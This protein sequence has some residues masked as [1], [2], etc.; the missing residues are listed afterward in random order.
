MEFKEM[1]P[2]TFWER[3][4]GTLGMVVLAALLIGG[5]VL[6]YSFL[7]TLILLAE[8]TLYLSG[9]LIAL[10]AVI[11]MVLDPKMRNLVGFAYKSVM[12][13]ITSIFVNIDPI[14]VLKSYI[15]HLDSSLKKMDKQVNQLRGQMHKL[16]ELIVNN[17]KEIQTNL[18]DAA[19]ARD[20]AKETQMVLKTRKAGRLQESN[21]RL[22]ELYK[23]ME[24][25]YRILNKM[26]DASYI[27]SEDLKDQILVKET[28]RNAILA[29]HSAMNS[30]LSILK[31]DPDK[32]AMF[33]MALENIS[34]DVS[35]KIGEMESFMNM[36]DK[37]MK[38]IDLQNGV[39][40][41][42]GLKMLE[43]WEK[44]SQSL[45]LG[46]AKEELVLKN[47]SEVETLDINQPIKQPQREAGHVNQYDTFFE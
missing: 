31:G 8:N 33:D 39:F 30:A 24:S 44:K 46:E 2:K 36:S 45:L 43:E 25:L 7:P 18:R 47:H 5:G 15:E 3:P 16:K 29:S 17:Q 1:K 9:M 27:M 40:E 26:R 21:M 12:R 14:G 23:R 41:E 37:I 4:E 6:L 32:K 38:G 34:N 42:D 28:E 10:A 13:W 19:K 20:S 35:A 22:D 11:Y